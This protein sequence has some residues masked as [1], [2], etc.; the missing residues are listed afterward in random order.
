MPPIDPFNHEVNSEPTGEQTPQRNTTNE[1][2]AN[3]GVVPFA[4]TATENVTLEQALCER[5]QKGPLRTK[6]HRSGQDHICD[7]ALARHK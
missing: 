5:A 2:E 7:D 6:T 1:A 4:A 3:S